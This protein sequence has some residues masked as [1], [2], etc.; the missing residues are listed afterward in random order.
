MFFARQ[1]DLNRHMGIHTEKTPLQCGMC[2]KRFTRIDN[3]R[4]HEAI[5]LRNFTCVI[6]LQ[7]FQKTSDLNR[8]PKSHERS[9][10]CSKCPKKFSELDHLEHHEASHLKRCTK[11]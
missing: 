8:H 10:K 4:V 3:L 7:V 1:S 11:C 6:C 2:F 5:H 9:Y